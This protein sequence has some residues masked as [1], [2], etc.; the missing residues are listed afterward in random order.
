MAGERGEP[1]QEPF[2]SPELNIYVDITSVGLD[3]SFI[4]TMGS[5][6]AAALSSMQALENGAIANA[7]ER[8]MVGHYWLRSPELAPSPDITRE[9][10][11]AQDAVSLF[12]H[13]VRN[14]SVSGSG[15]R[16]L[17][18]LHVGIGGSALGPQLLYD[19]LAPAVPEVAIHFLDNADPDGIDRVLQTL[20]AGLG[21]TLVSV[22]SK[23]GFTPTP[24]LVMHE[25]RSAYERAG[26]DMSRQA[27]ATTMA[28]S[29]LD[30]LARDQ[31]WLARFPL[32]DWVG[33]RT[34]VTSSV[35][36]LPAAL[37]MADTAALLDGAA[38]MDRLTRS[39][40]VAENPAALLA[41]AWYW[42]GGGAG[43]KSMVILPYKDR[44]ALLPRY[45]QQLAMES[46]GK[47]LDRAGRVVRQ[48][49][50]VYGN[51]GCTDQHAYL[52]QLREGRPDSFVTFIGV[53]QE[54]E[55]AASAG[56]EPA[57]TL[58]DYLF[59]N[60]EGTRKALDAA[61]R[62]SITIMLPDL[63]ARTLGATIALYERAVGL[64]AELVNVNAYHQPGV[65]K[66]AAAVTVRLH[67]AVL[68]F[69]R[70]CPAPCTAQRIAEG[71]EAADQ[72][73]SVYR[74]LMNL[75]SVGGRCLVTR[76]GTAPDSAR[77]ALSELPGSWEGVWSERI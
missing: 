25:L 55:K 51:K 50:T 27:V 39:H 59:A 76:E 69:L 74:L 30:K 67:H 46:L 33:G 64:Y 29:D 4:D 11:A 6:I 66:Y 62:P 53:R 22:V 21:R 5:A 35:G 7:D 49:L 61:G 23:S 70:E 65:D 44:L 38:T 73:D 8:R 34:S 2:S 45:I 52:Q 47:R 37:A 60:M 36:L 41:L 19:V 16:F 17:D 48:G 1:G 18:V 58:G 24:T 14:G 40:L 54:R 9:I 43:D 20:R 72:A 31:G 71:I 26:I 12:A 3:T 15:G 68:A 10:R 75:S 32:W 63:S 77:F 56:L 13:Q 42:L 57:L 28:G